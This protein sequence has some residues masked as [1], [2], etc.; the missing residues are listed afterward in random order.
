MALG[1]LL[2]YQLPWLSV[3]RHYSCGSVAFNGTHT[4][5]LPTSYTHP[6]LASFSFA[7]SVACSKELYMVSK[8]WQ[9]YTHHCGNQ[10]DVKW[11]MSATGRDLMEKK[12]LFWSAERDMAGLATMLVCFCEL[13]TNL[14]V[15]GQKET[16]M[17]DCLHQMVLW[18]CLLGVFSWLMT[19]VEGPN[20]LWVVSP[21][22]KWS[23]VVYILTG[24]TSTKQAE[25]ATG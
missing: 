25:Q 15:S 11:T 16:Q 4:Q 3:L 7:I 9:I 14:D 10:H 1:P 5:I 17:R 23:W 18:A 20:P 21:L 22:A 8:W 6:N 24:Q 19:D 13:G 2:Y 12:Q